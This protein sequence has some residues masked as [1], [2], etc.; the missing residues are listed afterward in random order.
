MADCPLRLPPR[1][2]PYYYFSVVSRQ[3]CDISRIRINAI[4][5][6]VPC[7]NI[8]KSI[9][10]DDHRDSQYTVSHPFRSHV[11]GCHLRIKK[12]KKTQSLNQTNSCV[13]QMIRSEYTQD[14]YIILYAFLI[15]FIPRTHVELLPLNRF[16]LIFIRSR[17]I[18][19][20]PA[21]YDSPR[22]H[23]SIGIRFR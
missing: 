10:I 17:R 3:L 1:R 6:R 16:A 20:T 2:R 15:T 19:R 4:N 9:P 23:N 5:F 7:K 13:A 12:K 22:S 8:R 14:R 18:R 11:A 21:C